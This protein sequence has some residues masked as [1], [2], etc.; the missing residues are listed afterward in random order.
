MADLT[1]V[2]DDSADYPTRLRAL[3][4][5]LVDLLA[6]AA[7]SAAAPLAKQLTDVLARL[8]AIAPQRTE[9]ALDDLAKARAR[10]RADSGL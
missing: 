7:P 2:T 9:S 3:R 10:R 8:E 5:H 1:P 6:D 4:D